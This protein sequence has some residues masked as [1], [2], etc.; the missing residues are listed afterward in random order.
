[1]EWLVAQLAKAGL[2]PV[3]DFVARHWPAFRRWHH[4]YRLPPQPG[5]RFTILVAD[6]EHDEKRT[7]TR[8]ILRALEKFEGIWPVGYGQRL[9]VDTLGDRHAAIQKAEEDAR[10]WLRGN[11][12]DVLVWGEVV[13]HGRVRR[14]RFISRADGL[15]ADRGQNYR[16]TEALELPAEFDERI[17]AIVAATALSYVAPASKGSGQYLVDTLKPVM[18]R[19]AAL[20]DAPIPG[21]AVERQ[22]SLTRAGA[23]AAIAL[24]DQS[25][26]MEWLEAAA[27]WCRAASAQL[28]PTQAREEWARATGTLG[29]ALQRLGEREKGTHRLEE[30]VAAYRAALGVQRHD[31][32]PLDWATT[33]NNL[34]F[35]LE[36]LGILED[37]VR[38]REESLAA[39]R[40]ALTIFELASAAHHIRITRANIGRV[41]ALLAERRGAVKEAE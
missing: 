22:A 9:I 35:A 39:Y 33:Q 38:R 1:M 20:L 40:A 11:N 17:A 31:Q 12:A 13:E 28:A 26:D 8:H 5:D 27:R 16:L 25:G 19:V 41:E 32:L 23:S 4:G 7:E 36:A 10:I 15:K 37:G 30:S 6:L 18:S 21:L 3:L 29:N 24:G 14:L 2:K 34:A